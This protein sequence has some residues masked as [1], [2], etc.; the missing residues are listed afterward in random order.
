MLKLSEMSQAYLECA[1]WADT[2]E[3]GQPP[4]DAPLSFCAKLEANAV[5]DA[6]LLENETAIGQHLTQ[7]GHD[8]WLTRNG[9]GSG[10]WARPELYGEAQSN[11]LTAAAQRLKTRS[12]YQGDDGKLYFTEG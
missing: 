3:E 7:A 12:L 2:G 5:C 10:F 11:L 1:R 9:H 4:A 6:F 8:L